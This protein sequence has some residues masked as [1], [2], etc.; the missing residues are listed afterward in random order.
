MSTADLATSILNDI[1]ADE[2]NSTRTKNKVLSKM[3]VL[4]LRGLENILTDPKVTVEDL[5]VEMQH[6]MVSSPNCCTAA[7][8]ATHE[9][10]LQG[11]SLW[12]FIQRKEKMVKVAES[13]NACV[14]KI[15]TNTQGYKH[16][17]QKA[18][19]QSL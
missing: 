19:I 6:M 8:D 7:W 1:S 15:C 4:H 17:K 3:E 10:H 11:K 16:I 12:R 18:Q 13:E 2:Q 9:K 5:L 14:L